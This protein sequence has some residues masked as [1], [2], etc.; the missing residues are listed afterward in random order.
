MSD[1]TKVEEIVLLAIWQLGEGAY[2]VTIRGFVSKAL[3][4][5]F[6]YGNLYSILNQLERKELI[7][8]SA[9]EVTEKRRGRPRI[10]V[11]VTPE[12]REALKTAQQFNANLWGSVS[13]YSF[14]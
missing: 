14:D 8:K 7:L 3:G 6:S 2:G 13:R 4:K 9:G 12:G 11:V 5:E 1:L 10:A